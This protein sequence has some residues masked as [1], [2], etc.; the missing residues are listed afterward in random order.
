MTQFECKQ[1]HQR[2]YS[3]LTD[4][5]ACPDPVHTSVCM[6]RAMN[7]MSHLEAIYSK[8]E[9]GTLGVACFMGVM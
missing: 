7:D 1:L 8:R 9:P 2:F 4:T 6:C 3:L 5:G